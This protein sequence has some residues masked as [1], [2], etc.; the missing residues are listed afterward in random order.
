MSCH[1]Q[2]LSLCWKWTHKFA[3]KHKPPSLVCFFCSSCRVRTEKKN[4]RE[5]RGRRRRPERKRKCA[6]T[7]IIWCQALSPAVP[8]AHCAARPCRKSTA[9]SARVSNTTA[10]RA[11]SPTL[12][13]RL[14]HTCTGVLLTHKPAS[15][16][17]SVTARLRTQSLIG[18]LKQT[19]RVT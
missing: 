8:P 18:A 11:H 1:T 7:G 6:V 14:T 9:C 17:T 12:I 15:I 13:L 5:K 19:K 10:T 3:C 16:Y 2:P 4:S